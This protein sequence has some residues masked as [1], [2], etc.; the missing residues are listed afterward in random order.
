MPASE[1]ATIAALRRVAD[2]VERA[3]A[4][5][6]FITNGRETLR[7]VMLERDN[8]IRVARAAAHPEARTIDGLA[9][10]VRAKRNVIVDALRKRGSK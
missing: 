2:P 7:L 1:N 10:R 8:A 3:A 9:A 6:A 5:Q 4:C